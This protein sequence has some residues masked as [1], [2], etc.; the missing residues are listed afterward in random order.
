M[1][2]L[3]GTTPE[4]DIEMYRSL[5]NDPGLKPDMVKIYPNTVIPTAELY[6][7]YKDGRY[8]PYGE[9]GL[10]RALLQMKLDT[11]RYCRIS[12]LI[13]D[14]PETEIAA[15]NKI[16]NLRE[17]LEKELTRRGERC[18]CLRCR[19]I[20]RQK[21]HGAMQQYNNIQPQLF[22]ES[23][24]T[25]GGTEY[26][27]SFEDPARIAVY[28]FLRLRIPT[29]P[30]DRLLT[31]LLPEVA[32]A[33]FIRELHVYGQLVGIGQ[34]DQ[35]ASQHKGLGKQLIEEAEKIAIHHQITNLL[36]ISGVGVR[37]YYRKSG[38]KKINTYMGK[39]LR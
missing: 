5:F 1:P 35:D 33:A 15:G 25:I 23:Y 6:E 26:F 9:E 16:T 30:P 4:H 21:N 8:L 22:V 32:N 19:E 14:I 3:P 2:D 29:T 10:F 37:D 12:R 31:T 38:Y 7:W 13:R 28:G 17:H 20:S 24:D 36:V 39:V 18:V 34:T 27:L 11:P